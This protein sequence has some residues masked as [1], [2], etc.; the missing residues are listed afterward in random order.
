MKQRVL[1]VFIF[2]GGLY[3][4]FSIGH[5]LG[6]QHASEFVSNSSANAF[7]LT[8][9]YA[10]ALSLKTEMD[11]HTF[12]KSGNQFVAEQFALDRID[13]TIKQI[14]GIDYKN[15]AF[16]TEINQRLA[17]AKEYVKAA[18]NQAK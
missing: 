13:I 10:A 16:E 2:L 3:I 1:L 4:S 6:K 8:T 9:A 15:S 18:R 5:R 17:E 14:E 7:F 11:N 12:I